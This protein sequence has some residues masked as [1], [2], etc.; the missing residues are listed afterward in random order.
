M[1]FHSEYK[2]FPRGYT[3]TIIDDLSS[4]YYN[5][6]NGLID[7][8]ICTYSGGLTECFDNP[9]NNGKFQPS[10]CNGNS[11]KISLEAVGEIENGTE[12]SIFST[13]FDCRRQVSDVLLFNF[14]I[15]KYVL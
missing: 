15:C 13:G 7:Y 1:F 14:V 5:F 4:D 2:S 3:G 11:E 10:N 9:C 6:N 8:K 12:V